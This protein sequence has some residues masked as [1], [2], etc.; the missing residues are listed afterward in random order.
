MTSTATKRATKCSP[1]SPDACMGHSAPTRS[2]PDLAAMNLSPS[3]RL[4]IGFQLA[5]FAE[6]L[7]AEVKAPLSLGHF[8]ARLGA[9]IGVAVYP[10]DAQTAET[11]VNNAD[12]AM[13]RAKAE[14]SIEPRYYDAKLDE[15]IRDRRELA[16]D[17]RQAIQNDELDVHYQ[18][19]SKTATG[20]IT[21][22]EALLRWTHP[23]HGSIPPSMFI[24]IAEENGLIL[25]LGEWVMRR[26][27]A[28]ATRWDNDCRVAVNVSA[29]Q[30][31]HVNLPTLIH[32]VMLE[33]GLPARR[34]EIELT[35]TA[36]MDDRD[37]ALHVLRQIKA[38][39]VGVALDDFGTGYSSLQTLRAFPFDKI[40]L[41]RFFAAE[42]EGSPQSMAIVRAVLAL[43][44]EPVYPRAC[45]RRGNA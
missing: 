30:L 7:D 11:L 45:R 28:D 29:L 19:Q 14:G 13:Y 15:A 44:Q 25:A 10:S 1:S 4:P 40:K 8:E 33:T 20:E 24:P 21:G 5:A 43:G 38:L 32:Q 9:S 12:L 2:S 22:Y 36:L 27:C 26:A 23:K 17:L 42:L 18:V 39:G 3:P 34:L 35:E 37:R 41:D 6:R 31:A 16:S